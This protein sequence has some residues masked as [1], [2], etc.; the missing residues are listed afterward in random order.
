MILNDGHILTNDLCIGC[1]RCITACPIPGAN[2]TVD[3]DGKLQVEIDDAKCIHGGYCIEICPHNAREY[4]DDT[5]RFFADLAAGKAISVAVDPSFRLM[6][7]DKMDRLFGFLR[8]Q[9]VRHIYDISFGADIYT[10]AVLKYYEVHPG[11]GRIASF[12]PTVVEM[13]EKYYP[14]LLPHLLPVKSPLL[15]MAAYAHN[16][17]RDELPIAYL[18]PCVAKKSEIINSGQSCGLSYHVTYK[19]FFKYLE[20]MNIATEP[21]P[22]RA[23]LASEDTGYLYAVSDGVR[24]ILREY[25]P[26][27]FEMVCIDNLCLYSTEEIKSLF[28]MMG[29][30]R[31]Y[32]DLISMRNCRFGCHC[33][34]GSLQ[35]RQRKLQLP[36]ELKAIRRHIARRE[37]NMQPAE[38]RRLLYEKFADLKPEDFLRTFTDRYKQPF[39]LP[40]DVMDEIFISMNKTDAASRR[41]NCGFCGYPS[42]LEMARAIGKG[43]SRVENC[44]HYTRSE[45]MRLYYT[46]HLTGIANWNG[47]KKETRE[48]LW[49][50]AQEQYIIAYFDIKHFKMVNDLYGFAVGDRTLQIVAARL[51]DFV[52][53][54]G[55]CARSVSDRFIICMPDREDNIHRLVEIIETNV[56]RYNLDFPIS[57]DL[58]FYR[59][60]DASMPFE[61]MMDRARLAQLSIKGSFDVRWAFFDEIMHNKLRNEAWVTKEMNRALQERQFHVYLQPQYDHCTGKIHGAEALVRWIH[62]ERGI[63]APGEFIPTFEKNNFIGLMD[64]FVWEETCRLMQRWLQRGMPVVPVSVNLSRLEL[65]EEDLPQRLVNLLAK[66]DVPQYLINLEITESAYTKNPNQLVSMVEKLQKAGFLIEM[67]DFGSGYSSL[68]TLREMPVDIV[69]L[70]LRFMTGEQNKKAQAIVQSVVQMMTRLRLPVIAEGIE[71]Q[72]QA[73]FMSHIGCSVLQ[74]YFYSRPVTIEEFEQKLLNH[75]A[76]KE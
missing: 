42:C 14:G 44:I 26:A 68:N 43:Y 56:E 3:H 58:G 35:D 41:I 4:T 52:E 57:F 47:F 54:M 22:A 38:R 32:T 2:V 37:Q 61:V 5:E 74:G 25:M 33:S 60:T 55:T 76:N 12:C 13:I 9:G 17:L 50:H 49:D 36:A 65:Y 19:H 31:D 71:T 53:G 63:I 23:D 40:P 8:A 39:R 64:A 73:D 18:G 6:L 70:D 75:S 11:G 30:D 21:A 20:Q 15:C 1:N 10:W 72:E 34:Q 62:P 48:L 66:Y 59:I 29:N 69:K 67:D 27:D 7:P 46:D 24:D 45:A 28:D 51:R 16:Y